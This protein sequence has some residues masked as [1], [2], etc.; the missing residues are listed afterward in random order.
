MKKLALA[1]GLGAHIVFGASSGALAA[2][3][4]DN[5]AGVATNREA[6]RIAWSRRA[7]TPTSSS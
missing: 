3:R 6:S 2:Y 5:T 4:G 1:I 7:R